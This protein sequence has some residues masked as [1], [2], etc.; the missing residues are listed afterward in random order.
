MSVSFVGVRACSSVSAWLILSILSRVFSGCSDFPYLFHGLVVHLRLKRKMTVISTL[1]KLL[2]E[3]QISHFDT[4]LC[5]WLCCVMYVSQ[6]FLSVSVVC[7]VEI[8]IWESACSTM[9]SWS[10]LSMGHFKVHPD[11][12]CCQPYFLSCNDKGEECAVGAIADNH[13]MTASCS[14]SLSRS[15]SVLFHSFFLCFLFWLFLVVCL[16][17]GIFCY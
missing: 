3:L 15:C 7:L 14:P 12:R 5:W 13:H 17:W 10:V 11:Y 1:S 9:G 16:F 6:A 4:G 2:A 8:Y